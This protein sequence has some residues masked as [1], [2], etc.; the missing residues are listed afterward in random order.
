MTIRWAVLPLLLTASLRTSYAADVGTE[1]SFSI[2]RSFK[3]EVEPRF[4]ESIFDSG[5]SLPIAGD[6]DTILING[7]SPDEGVEFEA[8]V[9]SETGVWSQWRPLEVRRFPEGRFWAKAALDHG[10]KLRVRAWDA[11]VND[12]HSLEIYSVEVFSSRDSEKSGR[13]VEVS[14]TEAP[15][16]HPRSE[17]GAKPPKAPYERQSPNRITYHH[18]DGHYTTTLADSL[19][20]V[21]F[22]QDFH[23]NGR[24]WNDIGYHF[25]IDAAGN[26]FQGR[27]ENV[28]GAHTE[29]ANTDNIGIAFLGMYHPPR[30]DKVTRES[31]DAF[32]R[33]GRYLIKKYGIDPNSLKGHRDYK[34]TDCPGDELYALRAQLRKELAASGE[35]SAKIEKPHIIQL[36]PLKAPKFE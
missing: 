2:G 19:N 9:V 20:E 1:V 17:W 23:M 18:T 14:M 32:L 27:P 24:G 21:R 11:G 16:V 4:G 15:N 33:L 25:L 8:S 30:N 5:E 13:A 36:P 26:I 3:V 34:S 31:L 12:S 35:V 10:R 28:I 29:N 6:W 7:V 22:I